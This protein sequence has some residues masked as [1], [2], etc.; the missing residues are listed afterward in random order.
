MP[1]N[2]EFVVHEVVAVR[3]DKGQPAKIISQQ[4]K[5]RVRCSPQGSV[6]FC[7]ISSAEDAL[8]K[9][10]FYLYV[11]ADYLISLNRT[12]Y[13]NDKT[14]PNAK[15]PPYL[16]DVCKLLKD[17][18]S[19]TRLQFQLRSSERIQ[20]A[21]PSDFK[22]DKIPNDTA[23]FTFESAELLAAASS[24]SLYFQ[25]NV[26]KK[27]NFQ[28]YQ[29]IISL[30]LTD[31]LRRSYDNMRDL[32]GLYKGRGGKVHIPRQHHRRHG[33]PPTTEPCSSP[34]L[35]TT[36]SYGS[37][38]PFERFPRLQESQVSPPPYDECLSD[39]QSPR[40]NQDAKSPGGGLAPPEYG[41]VKPRHNALALSMGA[42]PSGKQDSD[43]HPTS[44]R[45]RS[46]AAIC[47]PR[48]PKDASRV[49]KIP[50]SPLDINDKNNIARLLQLFEEQDQRIEWQSKQIQKLQKDLRE[51]QRRYNELEA[52]YITLEN[53]QEQAD[54]TI[55]NLSI[56]VS[57]LEGKY[58]E[59]IHQIPDV[60]DEFKDLK[61]RI[62]DTFKDD[63][64]QLIEA[65]ME[66]R[67]EECVEDQA[68]EV[69]MRICQALQ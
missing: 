46:F 48:A 63:I 31:D 5:L 59:V 56:D 42:L 17:I 61:E 33:S 9:T 18:K 3:E 62:S 45:K 28:R 20:L 60:C 51:M 16:G 25:H 38:L 4:F 30:P 53:R 22:P 40:V 27:E 69:K 26:L 52:N 24:F 57:E 43:T 65:S 68:K 12:V 8:I 2:P 58:D 10:T 35:A 49:V 41:D 39:G 29:E 55:D 64:Y 21:V 19:V 23:R 11:T 50:P 44:K 32:R 14:N 15:N 66:K 36:A 34:A 37:T 7:L 54:D 1:S 67:I 6:L 47:S 13:H